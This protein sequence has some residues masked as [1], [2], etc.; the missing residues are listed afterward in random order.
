VAIKSYVTWIMRARQLRRD[1]TD[2]DQ[3]LWKLLR[4]RQVEGQK[5]RRQ[6]EFGPFLL[7]LY[8][9]AQ[10]VLVEIDGSQ[11]LIIEG[12]ATDENR[13]TYL[14]NAGIRVLRFTNREVL[15]ETESVL[16]RIWETVARSSP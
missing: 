1:A 16:T 15:L 9:P 12:L 8:C 14:Q 2:A 13:S 5:F 3:L 10:W 7:D 6:H 4:N 11:H